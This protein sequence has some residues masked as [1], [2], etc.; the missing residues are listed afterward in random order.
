[1]SE[2]NSDENVRQETV[3]KNATEPAA[4]NMKTEL[5]RPQEPKPELDM[6]GALLMDDQPMPIIKGGASLGPDMMFGWKPEVKCSHPPIP[7]YFDF[8]EHKMSPY[9]F[10]P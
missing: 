10:G 5:K 1:V 7:L 4:S 2:S 3:V 9:I 6:R 8:V